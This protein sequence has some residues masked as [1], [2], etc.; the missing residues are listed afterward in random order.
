MKKRILGIVTSL[1]LVIS[2]ATILPVMTAS[3]DTYGDYEYTAIDEDSVM[4]TKYTGTG[5]IVIVPSDI[6]GKAVKA[7]GERAF[8]GCTTDH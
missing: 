7:I 4:I 6:D 8:R 1:M 3:A 5:D 2:M